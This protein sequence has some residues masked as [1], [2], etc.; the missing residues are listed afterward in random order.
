M[1]FRQVVFGASDLQ[2]P[3]SKQAFGHLLRKQRSGQ[4]RSLGSGVLAW[5]GFCGD[6][7]DRSSFTHADVAIAS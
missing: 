5:L 7:T 4:Q 3:F 2:L 6:V 1:K